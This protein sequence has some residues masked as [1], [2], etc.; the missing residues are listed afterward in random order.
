MGDWGGSAASPFTTEAEVATAAGMGRVGA[1]EQ[2]TFSLALGDNFYDFGVE[3]V[4]DP[5]FQD[6]FENV[7]TATNLQDPFK[8]HVIAGNHDY[9]GSVDAQIEYSKKSPRWSFPQPYY[10][11]TDGPVQFIMIDTVILSGNSDRLSGSVRPSF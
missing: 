10:T 11:F 4:E 3:S 8:F 2:A 9:H 7:F 5:R 6:T 1:A